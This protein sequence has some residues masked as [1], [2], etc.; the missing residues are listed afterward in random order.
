MRKGFSTP[1]TETVTLTRGDE[2]LVFVLAAVPPGFS[3]SLE[4]LIP[5]AVYI[6]DKRTDLVGA[7]LSERNEL[8][9]YALLAKSLE[10]DGCIDARMPSDSRVPEQW[11]A[12]AGAVRQELIAANLTEGEVRALLAAALRV[13]QSKSILKEAEEAAKN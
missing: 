11:L 7:E 1:I 10:A 13:S 5:S 3:T 4:G 8:R 9:A 6:R 12:F 2:T